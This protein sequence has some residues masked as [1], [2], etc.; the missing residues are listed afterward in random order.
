MSKRSGKPNIT[1]H[2]VTAALGCLCASCSG[3]LQSETQAAAK[4]NMEALLADLHGVD[5]KIAEMAAHNFERGGGNANS[6]DVFH[7]HFSDFGTWRSNSH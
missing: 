4:P 5:S 2:I 6:L 3:E 7:N 1:K